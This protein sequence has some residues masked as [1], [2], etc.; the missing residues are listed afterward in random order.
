MPNSFGNSWLI[1]I[2]AKM[3]HSGN[4]LFTCKMCSTLSSVMRIL[5]AFEQSMGN[6]HVNW[7]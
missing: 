5:A 1:M 3:R 6:A 4:H 2:R 7:K